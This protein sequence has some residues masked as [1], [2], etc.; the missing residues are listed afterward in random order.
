[1]I[2][3]QQQ[4]NR[5]GKVAESAIA[6]YLMRRGRAILPVY[7][8]LIDEG[9]GPQLFTAEGSFVAP[10]LCAIGNGKIIWAEVKHKT[11]FT[12]HRITGRWT[13]GIDLRHYSDYQRVAEKT[14]LPVWIFFLHE[15]GAAKDS[16]PDSP[17]GLFGNELGILTQ[18]E[19]HRSDRWGKS[20]M[21][22]WAIEADGGAL[23]MIAPL[24]E[25]LPAGYCNG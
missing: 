3:A 22:Y 21:V 4:N 6:Q 15:G 5:F 11:A 8:K 24:S 14:R 1:M 9:K 23:K 2:F 16:P 25:V 19:N 18:R 13:T 7:E 12:W 10:D 20:G 17:S